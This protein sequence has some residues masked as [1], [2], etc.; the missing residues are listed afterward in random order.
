MGRVVV[1]KMKA[2][3]ARA[4][5]GDASVWPQNDLVVP[6]GTQKPTNGRTNQLVV[7]FGF[8]IARQKEDVP[9]AAKPLRRELLIEFVGQYGK[10][11]SD[12]RRKRRNHAVQQ[13]VHEVLAFK[14]RLDPV[15]AVES[16]VKPRSRGPLQA[17][18]SVDEKAAWHDLILT[19]FANGTQ[20][21]SWRTLILAN[22]IFRAI[23]GAVECR[24]CRVAKIGGHTAVPSARYLDLTSAQV[25]GE[26]LLAEKRE[27]LERAFTVS[28]REIVDEGQM[29]GLFRVTRTDTFKCL[30]RLEIPPHEWPATLFP[31]VPL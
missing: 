24:G 27:H 4:G 11:P 19:I 12:G 9:N 29:R 10:L 30:L 31:I 17:R 28:G 26:V 20:I 16:E 18:P 7:W 5:C 22:A 3:Q 13:F 23:P 25:E 2:P 21:G 14:P 8:W 6:V 1:R 15:V